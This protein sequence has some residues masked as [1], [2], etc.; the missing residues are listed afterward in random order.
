MALTQTNKKH[1]PHLQRMPFSNQSFII[2]NDEANNNI[3][4]I[5]YNSNIPFRGHQH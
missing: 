4:M 3:I 2:N 5:R 1:K